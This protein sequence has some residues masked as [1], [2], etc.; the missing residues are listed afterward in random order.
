[1]RKLLI[2]SIS[3][4]FLAP[5]AFAGPA[6]P[7]PVDI[8]FRKSPG[9]EWIEYSSVE[10]S[11]GKKQAPVYW[12]ITNRESQ[13]QKVSLFEHLSGPGVGEYKI[14]W[15]T[16]GNNITRKVRN[17]SKYRF[18]LDGGETRKF[19]V[20]LKGKS[21]SPAGLCVTPFFNAKG[22]GSGPYLY[23]L[24]VNDSGVCG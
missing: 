4:A 19:K 17:E 23:G 9:S 24:Y 2:A 7:A 22:D 3:L 10:K 6:P 1:M 8:D 18:S 11:V 21:N 15:L 12:R 14:R 5:I 20:T 13:K 16:A